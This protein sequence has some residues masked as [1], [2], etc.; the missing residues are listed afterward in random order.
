[1]KSGQYTKRSM[2]C[3][4]IVILLGAFLFSGCGSDEDNAKSLGSRGNN[5]GD[6]N[7]QGGKKDK[8]Q[9][10]KDDDKDITDPEG[11]DPE[12][13]DPEKDDEIV[14][15]IEEDA[16]LV[17][18]M[19]G[20]A[21]FPS[22]EIEIRH[23]D[24][25]VVFNCST[26]YGLFNIIPAGAGFEGHYLAKNASLYRGDDVW[27]VGYELSW[28]GPWSSPVFI[29]MILK[30]ENN[31]IGYVLIEAK[32]YDEIPSV[33]KSVLF[34]KINSEYQDVSEK[35]VNKAIEKIISEYGGGLAASK[36]VNS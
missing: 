6:D 1:M 26:D 20:V 3:V 18:I 16:K 31:I 29:K 4:F 9:G 22:L 33:L 36:G 25:N 23:S 15:F 14:D 7:D 28:F 34:P 24:K 32:P 17:K 35:Y 12:E 21:N 19:H 2:F 13:D 5:Q 30:L 10:E 27:W 8:P 11:L